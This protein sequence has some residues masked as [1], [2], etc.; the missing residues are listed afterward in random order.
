MDN[1]ENS[2]LDSKLGLLETKALSYCIYFFLI[3]PND[4]CTIF[5]DAKTTDKDNKQKEGKA[6]KSIYSS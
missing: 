2:L 4:Q 5:F 6:N 3:E 1:L